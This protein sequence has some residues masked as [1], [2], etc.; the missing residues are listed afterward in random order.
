MMEAKRKWI[1]MDGLS[2]LTILS[3]SHNF[4][5]FKGRARNIFKKRFQKNATFNILDH[6]SRF[7]GVGGR[8][9]LFGLSGELN[10]G[11]LQSVP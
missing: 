7:G 11:A 9:Q 5:T 3:D 6:Q 1:L 4:R 10:L 2:Q 8:R